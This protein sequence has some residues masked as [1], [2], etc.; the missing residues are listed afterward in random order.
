[1]QEIL[2][3]RDRATTRA[4]VTALV[5]AALLG[6]CAVDVDRSQPS[7]SESTF[8]LEA[9]A[10]AHAPRSLPPLPEDQEYAFFKGDAFKIRFPGFF[11][12][13]AETFFIW[14]L[15]TTIQHNAPY[16]S[17]SHGKMYGVFAPGPAGAT[18]HVDGQEGFDHYHVMTLGEGTHTF[19]VFL[20]FQ[21]PNF[22]AATFKAPL[23]E[24]E[25]N[26]A[27]AAGI[28]AAPSTTTAAGFGPLV[29]RV[30]IREVDCNDNQ[31]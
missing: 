17:N 18:H 15:G 23:S 10:Q 31:H 20:V 27:V 1:M 13:Q 3:I 28:L 11:T 4:L 6:G 21:G 29:I 26:A 2:V 25:I 30:P 12:A 9:A 7:E 22:N 5:G 24:R 8:A 16:P 19:D 14:N